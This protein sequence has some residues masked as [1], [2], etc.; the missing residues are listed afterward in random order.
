MEGLLTFGGCLPEKK[1][2]EYNPGCYENKI[3]TNVKLCEEFWETC[4]VKGCADRHLDIE[5]CSACRRR[6]DSQASLEVLSVTPG[7]AI[8]ILVPMSSHWDH[9][10]EQLA[11]SHYTAAF[12]PAINGVTYWSQV[13]RPTPLCYC[14]TYNTRWATKVK[15][16]THD[17]NS[18]WNFYRLSKILHWK[19]RW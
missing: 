11:Q 10:C 1:V 19:S 6:C 9:E 2:P 5:N 4:D 14:V 13:R 12:W 3:D 18:L 16:Q 17:H 8:P 7:L 15:P